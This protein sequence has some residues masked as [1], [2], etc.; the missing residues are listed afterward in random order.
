MLH[1]QTRFT[2]CTYVISDAT[3]AQ[4][5][6]KGFI[7]QRL[8]TRQREVFGLSVLLRKTCWVFSSHICIQTVGSFAD[9]SETNREGRRL[10]VRIQTRK[11]ESH[12]GKCK[13]VHKS[14]VSEISSDCVCF[15]KCHR[16]SLLSDAHTLPWIVSLRMFIGIE[17]YNV[18]SKY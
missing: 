8:Q 7:H 13:G 15:A 6:H 12:H 16:Y 10:M 18:I 9:Q 3:H 2:L 11:Q 14:H 4:S 17:A 5:E 1:S